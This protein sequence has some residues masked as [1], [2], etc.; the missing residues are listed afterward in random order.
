MTFQPTASA[1]KAA[2]KPS[3][4]IPVVVGVEATS[5]PPDLPYPSE[6]WQDD[7]AST[8]E[9]PADDLVDDGTDL[10]S[11]VS[12]DYGTFYTALSSSDVSWGYLTDDTDGTPFD[13][14]LDDAGTESEFGA[15]S[16]VSSE[17][18]T[19]STGE[20]WLDALSDSDMESIMEEPGPAHVESELWGYTDNWNL[21][22]Y[23]DEQGMP[24]GG[25]RRGLP[26]RPRYIR[27]DH[28]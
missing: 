5:S 15:P 6:V 4:E 22:L 3:E 1:T 28:W 7:S 10:Q 25:R 8:D 16:D 26:K 17:C 13:V 18:D 14:L 9:P 21:L 2:Q 24:R 11:N 12:S 27:D 23:D 20:T 19:T